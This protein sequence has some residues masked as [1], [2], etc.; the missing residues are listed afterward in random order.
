MKERLIIGSV[1]A[2]LIV[3]FGTLALVGARTGIFSDPADQTEDQLSPQEAN[4]ASDHD[5]DQDTKETKQSEREND[6]DDEL[7][8]EHGIEIEE[9]DEDEDEEENEDDDDQPPGGATPA[10]TPTPTP[11]PPPASGGSGAQT[12]AMADVSAHASAASC[13]SAI[14]G[15]VYDLT[16]W[17]GQHPGGSSRILSICGKD[18]S[19]AFNGQHAGQGAPASELSAFFVGNLS[20]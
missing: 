17:I 11:T 14:N 4:D 3:G 13:W 1:L 10:P 18:G 7:E 12:Y 6:D 2:V 5:E 9:E 20:Q 19:A 15:K 8:E 16:A